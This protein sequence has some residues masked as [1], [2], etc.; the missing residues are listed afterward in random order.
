M[1]E[2]KIENQWICYL[3][4]KKN[5]REIVKYVNTQG[6]ITEERHKPGAQK[7]D[8]PSIHQIGAKMSH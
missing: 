5:I 3:Y 2:L 6:W 1:K 4:H 7:R 8:N